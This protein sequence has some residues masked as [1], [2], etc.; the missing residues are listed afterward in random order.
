MGTIE[1]LCRALTDLRDYVPTYIPEG[2]AV[3]WRDAKHNRVLIGG[4]MWSFE[5]AMAL[6]EFAIA[7]AKFAAYLRS[8]SLGELQEVIADAIKDQVVL[9][10]TQ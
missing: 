3:S 2:Y 5:E 4:T 9:K 8:G 1:R 7:S 6:L 10:D